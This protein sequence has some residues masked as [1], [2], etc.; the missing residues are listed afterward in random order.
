V[1]WKRIPA[2]LARRA[3]RAGAAAVPAAATGLYRLR[4]AAGRLAGAADPPLPAGPLVSSVCRQAQ[5]ESEAFRAWAARMKEPPR[6]HRKTWEFCYIAQALFERGLLRPGARGLGFAVG[7]EP[8]PALFASFGCE[9]VATDLDEASARRAGWV[10]TGQHA[11]TLAVLNERGL[12]PP[13]EFA[14]RVSFRVVDMNAIPDDLRG[15]DF[16]WSSCSLEHLGSLAAGEAFV[17]RAMECLRPGGVAVHTTEYNAASNRF[18][19]ERGPSVIFRRRDVE[20][21]GE[22]LVAAG[23]EITLDFTEGACAMDYVVDVPPYRLEPHL[24]LLL[25]GFVSTS[26]GLIVRKAPA[27][28]LASPCAA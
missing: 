17:H 16:V 3:R 26:I 18:T 15:F 4:R 22:R 8:L 7:R 11:A 2:A 6:S 27:A 1:N 28:A 20:R 23:H 21:I 19:V 12:C 5:L 9:I 25:E 13:D 14:E 10:D 24:K